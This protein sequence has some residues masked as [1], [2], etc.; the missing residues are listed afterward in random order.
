MKTDIFV[1]DAMTRRVITISPDKTLVDAAKLMNKHDIGC[2][3]VAENSNLVGI[4]TE[5][6]FVRV[7]S[8]DKKPSAVKVKEVMSFPLKTISPN[9]SLFDAAKQMSK[10]GIRKLPVKSNGALLGIITAE[11][12]VQ[13]APQEIELLLELATMKAE[14]APTRSSEPGADGECEACGNYSQDLIRRGS[15]SVC[16]ECCESL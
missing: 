4:I 10:L 14:S 1:K 16:A 5:Y 2:L 8:K 11:D 6:D 7:V 13:I 9:E 3:V 12:I 15:M